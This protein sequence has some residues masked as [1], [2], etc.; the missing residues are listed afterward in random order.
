M[1]LKL[2]RRGAV[3][4]LAFVASATI[5]LACG[6]EFPLQLLDDRSTS[7]MQTPRNSFVYETSHLIAVNDNL[8]AVEDTGSY[9]SDTDSQSDALRFQFS[10]LSPDQIQRVTLMRLVDDGDLAFALGADL[11][12]AVRLYNAAAVDYRNSPESAEKWLRAKQRFQAILDLPKAEGDA[13]AVWAA[14]MLGKMNASSDIKR[15]AHAFTL[16]R[17]RAREGASDAWGLAVASYGEEALLYLTD[18]EIVCAWK[19]FSIG[20]DCINRIPPRNSAKA[21]SLYVEQAARGSTLGVTALRYMAATILRRPHRLAEAVRDPLTQKV[22][23]AYALAKFDDRVDHVEEV[24]LDAD[25]K[26]RDVAPSEKLEALIVAI[27]ALKADQIENTDR[28]A[29]FAY[30]TGRYDLAESLVRLNKSA[31]ASWIRAKLALR[32]G[33]EAGAA[34][35]YAEA[36]RAFP[37][38]DTS[39]SGE[40]VVLIKGEEGVLALARGQYV[41][42]LDQLYSAAAKKR[43]EDGDDGFNTDVGYYHDMAYVAERVLTVD[44]LRAYVD[45]HVPASPSPLSQPKSLTPEDYY[46]WA[47]QQFGTMSDDLRALLARRLV[48]SG[49]IDEAIGYFPADDDLRYAQEFYNGQEWIMAP[50]Q[51]RAWLQS[52]DNALKDADAAWTRTG[53]AAALFRAAV[54]VRTHGMEIMGYEQ[55]PDFTVFNGSYGYGV[56]RRI[57]PE[58]PQAA[59]AVARAFVEL[60]GPYVTDDERRRYADSEARPDKRFHYR[61]I[62]ADLAEKAANLLPPRSQAFAATLCIATQYVRDD[63]ERRDSLYRRYIKQGAMGAFGDSFGEDCAEPDFAAAAW[64]PFKQAWKHTIAWLPRHMRWWTAAILPLAA[65]ILAAIWQFRRRRIQRTVER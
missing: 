64:F 31:L 30:R 34:A 63:F 15:A 4:V 49:R 32:K 3:I 41:D 14:Y 39:V 50:Q 61:H 6:P 43:V 12:M 21:V 38:L 2:N 29:A 7:L 24:E 5:A 16:A 51:R 27:T 10:D 18:G 44:E 55:A 11:P 28:L 45:A 37:T 23:I 60:P 20:S 46:P 48:R 40:N 56:G 1:T 9:Y 65:A 53:G 47:A 19:E 42:A 8:R 59:T 22:L 58:A 62:A 25:G 17:Q 35:A 13:R 33:D 36:S 54:I 57:T 26:P 52:Y